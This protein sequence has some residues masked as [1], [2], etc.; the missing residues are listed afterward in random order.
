MSNIKELQLD[1]PNELDFIKETYD[2][3]KEQGLVLDSVLIVGTL[4]E[5]SSTM[6]AHTSQRN[7]DLLWLA[8]FSLEKVK[9]KVF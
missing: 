6:M 4:R 2:E 5:D 1:K 8:E 9:E 7:A 3:W